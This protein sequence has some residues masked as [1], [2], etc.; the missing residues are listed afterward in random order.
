MKRLSPKFCF[1]TFTFLLLTS[2]PSFAQTASLTKE[3]RLLDEFGSIQCGDLKARLDS[4]M[5]EVHNSKAP[6]K[7]YVVTYEGRRNIN[8]YGRNGNFLRTKYVLPRLGEATRWQLEMMEYIR[9]RSDEKR[10]PYVFI[11]GGYIENFT[12]QFWIVPN[13][14]KRLK[15]RPSTK[16][17]EYR[18]GTAKRSCSGID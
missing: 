11:S 17:A 10:I 14:S 5:I 2:A 15:I 6:A 18:R 7:G 13:G 1:L 12:V 3:A 9:H 8:V 16:K 4:L